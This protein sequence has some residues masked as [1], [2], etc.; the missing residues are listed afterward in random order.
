MGMLSDA[1]YLEKQLPY[2]QKK[3]AF[4]SADLALFQALD[5][6]PVSV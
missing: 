1:E 2:M 3:M 5:I 6:A 4:D